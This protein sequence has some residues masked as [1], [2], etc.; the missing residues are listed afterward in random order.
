MHTVDIL[1]NKVVQN[2][3]TVISV[4]GTLARENYLQAQDFINDTTINDQESEITEGLSTTSTTQPED[5]KLE[6][7]TEC[8]PTNLLV[9][10]DTNCLAGRLVENVQSC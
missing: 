10:H 4:D 2:V 5:S 1:T 6:Q 3:N 9:G 8:I 7:P